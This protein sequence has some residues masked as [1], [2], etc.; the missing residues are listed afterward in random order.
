MSAEPKPEKP[1]T[2][3]ARSAAPIAAANVAER[4][5]RLSPPAWTTAAHRRTPRGAD[6]EPRP[7][8]DPAPPRRRRGGAAAARR[9]AGEGPLPVALRVGRR[10]RGRGGGPGAPR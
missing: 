8:R 4:T 7:E 9:P 10:R 1:R 6:H 5:S 2:T 3:P